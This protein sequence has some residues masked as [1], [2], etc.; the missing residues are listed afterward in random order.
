MRFG[1]WRLELGEGLVGSGK[2]DVNVGE[3]RR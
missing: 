1:L 3:V 2:R